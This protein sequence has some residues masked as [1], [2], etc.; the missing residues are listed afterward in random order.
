MSMTETVTVMSPEEEKKFNTS[1][2]FFTSTGAPGGDTYSGES[3]V[4]YKY[5]KRKD[6]KPK[7]RRCI[8]L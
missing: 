4:S 1:H 7:K 8:I 2:N 5:K 6:E 3:M